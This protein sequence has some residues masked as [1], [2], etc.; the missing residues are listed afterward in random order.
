VMRLGPGEDIGREAHPHLD[1]FL[2]V[3]QGRARVSWAGPRRRSTR[4]TT[5]RPTGR[6]SFPPASGTTSSIRAKTRYGSTRS[7]RRPSTPKEPSTGRR[8]TPKRP[9]TLASRPES[10]SR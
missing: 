6:S 8:R 10:V 3:E 4:R 7:T 9:T 2:R 5:S 1:Q